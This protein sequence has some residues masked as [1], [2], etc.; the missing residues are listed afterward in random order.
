VEPHD[1]VA[2]SDRFL[3]DGRGED[4]ALRQ[5]R[6]VAQAMQGE[7]A[8]IELAAFDRTGPFAY[9]V[10]TSTLKPGWYNVRVEAEDRA[11]NATRVSRNLRVQPSGTTLVPQILVPADGSTV[12][13]RFAVTAIA[14]PQVGTVT[15]LADGAPLGV[16]R[17]GTN[18]V[19]SYIVEQGTLPAGDVELAVR[20]EPADGTDALVG[21]THTVSYT[22]EGPWVSVDTPGFLSFVRDRPFITGSAGYEVALPDGDDGETQRRRRE[23]VRDHRV[24]RVEVSLD[25]GRSFHPARGSHEWQYRLETTELPDGRQNLVIRAHYANG[26][27]AVVRHSVVVDEAAP[28]VRLLEPHERDTFDD[29]VRIVGV[30]TDENPLAD[31]SVVLREGDKSAYELPSFIQGLY[32]DVHAMGATYFDV[33]A[34]LSFFDNNVRLQ[35]QVGMSPAGRFSGLVLGTKLLA[36]VASLPASFFFGPDLEWLSGALALG[37]NFSYFTMSE[38]RIEFTDEGLVLA[39]MVAQLEFPIVTVP[40]LPVLNTYA[41]YTEAQLW[42]ISSDVEAGTAF[43]MSFGVRADVF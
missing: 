34:G 31:V 10:D 7:G 25:N 30:T 22:R 37:A 26:E 21:E 5:V 3:V 40:N 27:R 8:P 19:G 33:G 16:I 15:L 12:S 13:H 29:R 9:E 11:G 28:Q 39:G 36:N 18:G 35:A 23:L 14:D 42:F 38:D 2:V 41:F 32:L 43:R 24:E 6:L 17:I 4:E 20:A 1:G